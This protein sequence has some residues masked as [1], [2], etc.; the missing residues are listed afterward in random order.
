MEPGPLDWQRQKQGQLGTKATAEPPKG[1]CY[2]SPRGL[3]PGPAS[4]EK[5]PEEQPNPEAI[6]TSAGVVPGR[7]MSVRTGA[8]GGGLAWVPP[9]LP[10]RVS[11]KSHCTPFGTELR[12]D[13][14][15]VVKGAQ[16]SAQISAHQAALRFQPG[17]PKALG[18]RRS[19]SGLRHLS[20]PHF[21]QMGISPVIPW[22]SPNEMRSPSNSP[23][24]SFQ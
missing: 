15:S 22:A 2:P 21:P 3:H 5:G 7:G 4:P 10:L 16:A 18:K 11:S 24:S 23:L 14:T 6:N 9:S 8:S 1:S 20:V 17:H 13:P 19:V 12:L